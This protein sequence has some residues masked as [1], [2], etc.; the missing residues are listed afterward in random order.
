MCPRQVG[1]RSS[2]LCE[3]PGR[4]FGRI[5]YLPPSLQGELEPPA[6]VGKVPAGS[7]SH[8]LLSAFE[9]RV[10][11]CVNDPTPIKTGETTGVNRTMSRQ[12]RVTHFQPSRVS[13]ETCVT[14]RFQLSIGM[15][16]D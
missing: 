15:S 8:K 14:S 9:N 2:Y 7:Y 3:P 4:Q 1:G 13:L 10:L 5:C 12:Y 16:W 11:G 6:N